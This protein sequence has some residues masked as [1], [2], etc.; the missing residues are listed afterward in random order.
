MS[1]KVCTVEITTRAETPN[2]ESPVR[3]NIAAR[4]GLSETPNPA[5]RTLYDLAQFNATRWGNSPC[6][7]TRKIIK[8]H[9]EVKKVTKIVDG[10]TVS[11]DKEWLYWE[12]GPFTYRSYKEAV[13]EGLHVGAGL[14][15]LG[16]GKGDKVAIYAD[17]S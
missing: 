13:Q 15:K 2:G 3:R 7:G 8:I 10:N 5:I 14:V 9:R 16:L 4:D 12:L 11:V 6:F 1:A 17:T